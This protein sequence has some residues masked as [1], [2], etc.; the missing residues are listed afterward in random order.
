M[1]FDE[2]IHAAREGCQDG[3]L[4]GHEGSLLRLRDSA[5]VHAAGFA[6][7]LDR[8]LADDFRQFASRAAA[9][10]IHLPQ[11]I[12]GHRVALQKNRVLPRSSLNVRDAFGIARDARLR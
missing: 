11:A 1:G 6:I 9:Q 2:I 7:R 10:T 4:L 5:Q 3:S 8:G 12:L